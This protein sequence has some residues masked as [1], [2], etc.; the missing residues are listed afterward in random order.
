[1]AKFAK[2]RGITDEPAFAWW[3]P[4]TMRKSDLIISTLKSRIR[5]TTHKYGI[6]IPTSIE[7]G[8]RLDKENGNNFWRDANT[9]K[10]HNFGV[11][12][13]FLPEGQKSPV[14]WSKVTVHLIRDVNMDFTRKKI[15]FLDGHKNPDPI[16]STYPGVVSRDSVRI[17]FIYVA[18]N[19]I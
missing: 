3:V 12:F 16:R 14:V 11:S 6:E 7:H 15:W 10:M 13:D 2:A 4:Y 17:A 9:N 1:M 18:L 19:G 5:K 8:N